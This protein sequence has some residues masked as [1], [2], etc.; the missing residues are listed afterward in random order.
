MGAAT[1]VTDRKQ[2][3]QQLAETTRRQAELLIQRTAA[4][5]DSRERFQALAEVSAQ[6]VWTTDAAGVVTEDSP[7]WR[8]FTGQCL[9]EWLGLGWVN[10]VHPA[11]RAHAGQQ[12]QEAVERRTPISTRLRLWH[13]PTRSW[14]D[15][16]V[17][18]RP[19]RND[20][21]SVRGWMGMSIDLTPEGA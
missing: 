11:D 8:A 17:R 1:D 19:L 7:S 16:Q 4:L 5:R 20:D 14:R 2:A 12:W 13:A 10:A 18:A 21:G 15:T 9:D 3:E 6:V